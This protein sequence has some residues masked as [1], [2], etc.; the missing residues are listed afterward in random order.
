[1]YIVWFR[2]FFG[3]S[4]L[5]AAAVAAGAAAAPVTAAAIANFAVVDSPKFVRFCCQANIASICNQY[6]Q[7]GSLASVGRTVR[8]TDIP[9]HKK[10]DRQTDGQ[11]DRQIDR[12]TDRQ[13]EI[14]SQT[15]NGTQKI[16]RQTVIETDSQADCH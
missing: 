13:T 14:N 12:Q 8:D 11:S 2:Y 1:M 9:A 3:D 5:P 6:Y 4:A 15:Y 7:G 10:T 16:N